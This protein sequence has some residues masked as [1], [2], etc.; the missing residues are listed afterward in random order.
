MYVQDQM[1][2]VHDFVSIMF[3]LPQ[4]FA[5]LCLTLSKVVSQSFAPLYAP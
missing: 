3:S 4:Y 5:M 2:F 1:S